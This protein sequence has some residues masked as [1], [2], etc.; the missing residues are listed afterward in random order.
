MSMWLWFLLSC[1]VRVP[2]PE[3]QPVPR[4]TAPKPPS[5]PALS[6]LASWYGAQFAGRPTA[7]GVPFRPEGMTAAHRTLPFGTRVRVTRVDTG[8]QVTVVINDRG[9]YAG[10]RII[11][12]S[13]GAAEQLGMISAGVVQVKL[14]V[15]GCDESYG[16]CP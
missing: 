3:P 11:D 12:L 13:Q 14:T 7:S 15:V 6:G 2:E 8:A 4:P 5:G 10:G 16:R 9:P 1:K